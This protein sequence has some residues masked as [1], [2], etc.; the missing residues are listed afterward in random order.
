MTT[1]V[2][3]QIQSGLILTLMVLGIAWRRQRAKH[4]RSMLTVIVWDVLLI[5]QIELSREA[6]VK[7]SRAITNP[8]MLNIHVSLALACVVLYVFMILTGRKLLKG[9]ASSRPLHKKLGWSTLIVR[10]LVF[11]TSFFAVSPS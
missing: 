3:F 5:L 8:M 4:V 10:V 1:A 7:A 9:D 2:L 6:V 11:A